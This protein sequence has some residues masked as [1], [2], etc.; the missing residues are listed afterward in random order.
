MLH[1]LDQPTV[2][3]VIEK[4]SNVGVQNVV[5]FLL[6]E[7]IRQR[8]QRLM[9]AAPRPK[10]IR[11][12]EK[13]LLVNLVE[14]GNHG[15]L[16]DLVLQGRD[17]QWTL[18]S[19]C[20]RYVHSSRWL[21]SIS[22]TMNP[23]VQIGESIFQSGFILLPCDAVHSGCGFP[24]QCV[25]A[26]PQQIDRQMVEQGGELHL[27]TFPCCFPHTRQ[28]LGHA[29]PALCRVRVRLTSVLL[30]QRPSLLTLRRRF[31]VFVRMIHRYCSAV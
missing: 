27:L 1:E 2:V 10:S 16:D 9:L 8:I 13:V 18:S 26:F 31:S 14:D 3:E 21:R 19:I 30:D 22:S 25:K 17:P 29:L 28:P 11:E 7:R 24:L 15:L 4:A 6:Q 5:H 20:F 12:A 23:A